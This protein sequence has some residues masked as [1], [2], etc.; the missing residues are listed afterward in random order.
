MNK[1]I[2]DVIKSEW[3]EKLILAKVS[4]CDIIPAEH[5]FF[6]FGQNTLNFDGNIFENSCFRIPCKQ[7]QNKQFA[8][9][10]EL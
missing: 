10:D 2:C 3:G 5:N 4:I 1:G 8:N 9:I 6:C 7:L